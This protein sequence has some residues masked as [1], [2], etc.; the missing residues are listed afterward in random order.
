MGLPTDMRSMGE[1]EGCWDLM[2]WN[3]LD[4]LFFITKPELRRILDMNYKEKKIKKVCNSSL[5]KLKG[6][7]QQKIKYLWEFFLLGFLFFF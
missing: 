7:Y 3:T 4:L 2:K 5:K 6:H 1:L